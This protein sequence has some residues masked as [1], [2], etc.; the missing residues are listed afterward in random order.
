[1]L[2][3]FGRLLIE[4]S[5][6]IPLLILL[7]DWKRSAILLMVKLIGSSSW[8]LWVC[9]SLW[10]HAEQ[11]LHGFVSVFVCVKHI[12][13]HNHRHM[14]IVWLISVRMT[15][16]PC[17]L[18]LITCVGG[19]LCRK[20]KH[21]ASN[22]LKIPFKITIFSLNQ[23]GQ[24]DPMVVVRYQAWFVLHHSADGD[25][26][27]K[28]WNRSQNG[29]REAGYHRCCGQSAAACLFLGCT[30]YERNSCAVSLIP[31]SSL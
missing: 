22:F 29:P 15:Q 27:C 1:M 13:A 30:L 5:Q 21:P 2:A 18:S 7:P 23:E 4:M 31:F 24:S 6:G 28:I 20:M 3:A 19:F 12:I 17:G 14:F 16:H 8:S 10:D 11:I 26:S 9:R 25:S